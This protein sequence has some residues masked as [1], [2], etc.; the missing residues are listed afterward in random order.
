MMQRSTVVPER[1]IRVLAFIEAPAVVGPP[2]NLLLVARAL[3][4]GER[5]SV[6]IRIVTFLRGSGSSAFIQACKD[7][8]VEIEII[9]ERH[10][11]DLSALSQL[12]RLVD[13]HKPDIVQTHNVKSH[14]LMRL[15]GVRRG[16]PWI[17]FNHGYT[18]EDLKMKAY[19]QVDRWSLRGA[20]VV[21]AVCD[22]F[23]AALVRR[24]VRKERIAVL[25]N[26]VSAIPRSSPEE[27]SALRRSLEIPPGAL[28]L[29]AVGRLSPEKA[30]DHLLQAIAAL[31]E[32][33][34]KLDFR[35][36]MVGDG[37]DRSHV[38]KLRRAL[39]LCNVVILA[40]TTSNVALY[41]SLA[42]IFVLPSHSE[43]SPNALLEAM[44]AGLP[45]VATS[46]GG[47]PEIVQSGVTGLLVPPRDREAM[48]D[49]MAALIQDSELRKRLG[50]QAQAWVSS[51]HSRQHYLQSLTNL[52]HRVAGL[53][54]EPGVAPPGR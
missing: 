51:H 41:Y 43:G 10:R 39:G 42:D 19:N 28:I 40:G 16:V 4:G 9:R 48:A 34:V 46:V 3:G 17:A 38:E 50:G 1:P 44:S 45:V 20:N 25:H 54:A 24:G 53:R 6:S 47:V 18:A 2:K 13:L 35:L 11:F 5:P 15:A 37:P 32:R 52:Y 26:A 33:R 49:G 29:L 21:V 36:V 30:P 23:G 7:A 12:R 14:F 31:Q 27:V 22:A 8:G